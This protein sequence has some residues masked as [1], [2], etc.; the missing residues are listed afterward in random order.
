MSEIVELPGLGGRTPAADDLLV[1]EHLNRAKVSCEVASIGIRLCQLKHSLSPTR[2]MAHESL[3]S[4]WRG[5][6]IQEKGLG[7]QAGKTQEMFC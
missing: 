1:Y 3:E 7:V 4:R 2:S 6:R 5:R